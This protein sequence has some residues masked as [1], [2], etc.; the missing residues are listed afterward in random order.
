MATTSKADAD[1]IDARLVRRLADILNETGLTEIEVE[2]S[3]LKVRVAKTLTAAPSVHYA[4]PPPAAAPAP[5]SPAAAS[6]A[7]APAASRGD[8]VKSPMVGT[9]YLQPTPGAP[10]FV[11]VGDTVEAGQTLFIIE[12]MKTMNPVPAP[13]AGTL[14]EILIEDAQP[15][16]FGEPLAI[17][18]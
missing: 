6:A 18:G 7:A 10:A 9:V 4:A 11:K 3:G 12:A 16:E 1:P 13:R 17:I 15:V 14:V 2:H 5:A 8:E